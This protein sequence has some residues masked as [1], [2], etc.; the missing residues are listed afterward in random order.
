MHP[1]TVRGKRSVVLNLEPE[2]GVRCP[3]HEAIDGHALFMVIGQI[4]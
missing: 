3:V 1:H 4:F 2:E